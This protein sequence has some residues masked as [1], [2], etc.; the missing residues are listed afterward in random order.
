VLHLAPFDETY[1]FSLPAIHI[2][3][4][5]YGAPFVELSKSTYI[6]STSGFVSRIDYSGKGW[7]SGRKNSFR[8]VLYPD[9][10]EKDILY[11]AEGQW[12]EAFTIREG[13]NAGRRDAPA[14][15][16]EY[17]AADHPTTPLRVAP[18]DEQGPLEAKK[19]WGPTM[20][21][22]K[23]G[24]MDTVHAEKSKIENTQ[25]EL[26]RREA[27]EGRVWQRRYFSQVPADPL[28]DQLLGRVTGGEIEA[29]KTNGIW[30][31]DTEKATAVAAGRPPDN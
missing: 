16:D 21:A 31:F 17:I 29:D 18:L 19:A 23:R 6:C 7:L 3:G 26:R 2:E 22:I 13:S 1:M 30:R 5:Y 10:R 12:N 15:V 27:A 28:F 20:E 11:T 8:A 14:P 25:R 24:D 9:G 4:L